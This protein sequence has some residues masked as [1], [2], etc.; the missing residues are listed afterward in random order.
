M[1]IYLHQIVFHTSSHEDDQGSSNMELY[2]IMVDAKD[3]VTKDPNALKV[4]LS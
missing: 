4:K 2:N 3:R 1:V